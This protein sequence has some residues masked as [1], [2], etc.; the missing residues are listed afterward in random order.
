MPHQRNFHFEN[1][2]S[3]LAEVAL[4][5]TGANGYGLFQRTADSTEFRRLATRGQEIPSYALLQAK[6]P[7][8]IVFPL[9]PDGVVAFSFREPAS[10]VQ[11][12]APLGRLAEAMETIWAAREFDTHYQHL[13]GRLSTL[14]AQLID[15]KI[16][17][18]AQGLLKAEPNADILDTLAR[19]VKTVLRPSSAG[20]TIETMVTELEDEIEERRVTGQAKAI[21]QA[22]HSISEEQAYTQLRVQSRKSRRRLKEVALD[23][24]ATDALTSNAA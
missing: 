9:G 6:Q 17:D 22:A 5:E 23:V 19:H 12:E 15:S 1:S 2:L 16:A 10:S 4:R 13:L 11:A 8:V 21:L 3:A 24:I 14:E 20:R 18:R 7:G